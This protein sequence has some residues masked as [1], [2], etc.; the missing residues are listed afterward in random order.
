MLSL[1]DCEMRPIPGKPKISC[2]SQALGGLSSSRLFTLWKCELLT[3][4]FPPS[5]LF[6]E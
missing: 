3:V 5:G 1:R 4:N 2:C 6:K